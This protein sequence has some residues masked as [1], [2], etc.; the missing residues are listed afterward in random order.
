MSQ[1]LSDI[2]AALVESARAAYARALVLGDEELIEHASD[3]VERVAGLADKV[4]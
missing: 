2:Y 1:N 3:V 4:V